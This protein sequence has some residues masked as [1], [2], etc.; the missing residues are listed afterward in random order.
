MNKYLELLE[1]L[2]EKPPRAFDDHTL[3]VDSMNTFLRNFSMVKALNPD[4]HH[5]GGLVGFL[6]S[7]GYLIRTHDPTQ[8]VCVFDGLGASMHK[9]NIDPAYKANREHMRVTNWGIHDTKQEEK[10]S[11]TSQLHRLADYLECL[12]VYVVNLEK[13]EADDVIAFLAQELGKEGKRTTIV[14]TDKDFLQLVNS[15][16]E[17][18]SP[19]KRLTF[20][21]ENV[22]RELQMPAEN[23][24]TAKALLGDNSDNLPGVP[25]LGLKTLL[26]E[27]PEMKTRKG[28]TLEDIY[29]VCSE[30]VQEKRKIF[31]KIIYDWDQVTS[32]HDLMNLKIPRVE[33]EEKDQIRSILREDLPRLQVGTFL[34]LLEQDKVDGITNTTESWL[35]TFRPLTAYR[36][37]SK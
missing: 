2:K 14:S 32:N 18:Y 36:K 35:E 3:I 8:V 4:G 24:L 27:F 33:E 12:P 34:H 1:K 22:Q 6:R 5:V 13:I 37:K 19:I 20:T 28:V 17:V 25:R 23:Y 21:P 26:K 30:R 11:I 9:R 15:T 7:L 10:N 29:K 31:A 16:V